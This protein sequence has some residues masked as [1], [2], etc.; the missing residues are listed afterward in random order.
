MR[1]TEDIRD[2]AQALALL[3]AR[4]EAGPCQCGAPLDIELIEVTPFGGIVPQFVPGDHGTCSQSCWRRDPEG[5]LRGL[6][7]E[8]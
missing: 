8:P 1:R 4:E 2:A 3:K 6:G 5:F 7:L